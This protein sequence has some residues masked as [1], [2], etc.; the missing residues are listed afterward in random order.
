MNI[1]ILKKLVHLASAPVSTKGLGNAG[2]SR[3][4][5]IFLWFFE[6]EKASEETS[7]LDPARSGAKEES[8]WF[9]RGKRVVFS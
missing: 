1:S 9:V 3:D 4:L 5:L 2:Q 6:A 8:S 7:Q